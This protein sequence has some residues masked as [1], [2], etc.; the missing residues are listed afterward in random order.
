MGWVPKPVPIPHRNRFWR[1]TWNTFFRWWLR[2]RSTATVCVATVARQPSALYLYSFKPVLS[3]LL[4]KSG[5]HA[6]TQVSACPPADTER[7]SNFT[8]LFQKL[9]KNNKK[10]RVKQCSFGAALSCSA[11]G[12]IS[13][14]EW[15]VWVLC[16]YLKKIQT[17]PSASH[18]WMVEPQKPTARESRPR[19]RPSTI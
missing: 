19:Q 13:S 2:P 3:P 4:F 17:I 5:T 12:V 8:I 6:D 15:Q 16:R 9:K 7:A 10:N 1:L 18:N 14:R 11:S